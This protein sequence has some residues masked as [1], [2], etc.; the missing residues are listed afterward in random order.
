MSGPA[1]LASD[2]RVLVATD[3][4]AAN[5][6]DATPGR[7]A[8]SLLIELLPAGS[9]AG[10]W[11]YNDSVSTLGSYGTVDETWRTN[12][13]RALR[14]LSVTAPNP[15][16]N[17]ESAL[18]A[19]A[20]KWRE[21]GFERHVILIMSPEPP[22]SDLRTAVQRSRARILAEAIPA[23][24]AAR[25][26]IHVITTGSDE[27]PLAGRLAAASGGL[28]LHA[29][30]SEE[31]ADRVLELVEM[32]RP[33]SLP[34]RHG[35]IIIDQEVKRL[36]LVMP[37]APQSMASE[38]RAPDGRRYRAESTAELRWKQTSTHEIVTIE[39][40]AS[41]VWRMDTGAGAR[42]WFDGA[43]LLQ[44]LR[45]PPLRVL[46][47]DHVV[48]HAALQE[49]AGEALLTVSHQGPDGNSRLLIRNVASKESPLRIELPRH[50]ESGAHRFSIEA[51]GA[52]FQR[53]WH[54]RLEILDSPLRLEF[55][56]SSGK[57]LLSMT[58]WADILRHEDLHIGA[59]L[60]DGRRFVAR[61]QA[62]RGSPQEWLID[63]AAHESPR[64]LQLTL[65]TA[66]TRTR[67]GVLL[68]QDRPRGFDTMGLHPPEPLPVRTS[69]PSSGSEYSVSG[70]GPTSGLAI[71]GSIM[72]LVSTLGGAALLMQALRAAPQEPPPARAPVRVEPRSATPPA[73]A[74]AAIEPKESR[75]IPTPV[76]EPLPQAAPD[77]KP[78]GEIFYSD[79]T[80][81]PDTGEAT[82]MATEM[83]P[84]PL[85]P[86][87]APSGD[88]TGPNPLD[89]IDIT[90]IELDFSEEA[91]NPA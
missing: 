47:G 77:P 26:R 54:Q 33:L 12:A 73:S 17:L 39:R 34:V 13:A 18:A 24:R 35:E 80:V 22:S 89:D 6:E 78:A 66:G 69:P 75:E 87:P 50:L 10:I 76:T 67:G 31:L 7:D 46:A 74:T 15:P 70:T 32:L 41:G 55:S 51:S 72:M 90:G 27:I 38:L 86:S 1:A 65:E 42:V 14:D 83:A 53:S 85:E 84:D 45:P 61:L 48:L 60:T 44:T 23:L 5:G 43:A 56:R 91:V 49:Q 63:L 64:L 4:L 20:S 68:H 57:P 16:I 37:R 40:P 79:D 88:G 29:P 9:R 30:S 11:T 8:L 52:G 58:P 59:T 25:V 62:E 28:L 82:V 36:T 19:A 3:V 81:L 21:S 2:L 71:G